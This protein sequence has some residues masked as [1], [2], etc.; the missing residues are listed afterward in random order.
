MSDELKITLTALAGVS[1][2]VVGQII[3]KLFIEPIQEHR[4]SIG[5]VIY[6][7][8]Y[9]THWSH[10]LD[11]EIQKEAHLKLMDAAA[12]LAATL[13]VIPW[14]GIFGLMTLVPTRKSI[15]KVNFALV[16]LAHDV[17]AETLKTCRSVVL[18]E[19]KRMM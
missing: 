9:Y 4:R 1:V 16:E 7:L 12:N 17:N 13:C 2:F 6:I 18:T 8:N 11:Y 10:G 19:L 14:Y 15:N 5:R 3:Q